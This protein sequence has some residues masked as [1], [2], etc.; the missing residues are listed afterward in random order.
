MLK[1][2]ATTLDD[3]GSDNGEVQSLPEI[4]KVDEDSLYDFRASEVIRNAR[5][6]ALDVLGINDSLYSGQES[7]LSWGAASD[8]TFRAWELYEQG[9]M[10]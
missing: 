6:L 4:P 5:D 2:P 10:E 9:G 1:A 8:L 3:F 7:P